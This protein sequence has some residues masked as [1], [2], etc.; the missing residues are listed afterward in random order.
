MKPTL[1]IDTTRFDAAL[2]VMFM[3]T[4][5][6][7]RELADEAYRGVIGMA[8]G[9]TPPMQGWKR[10]P[11]FTDPGAGESSWRSSYKPDYSGGKAAGEAGVRINMSALFVK[12]SKSR[13]KD[14]Q[15]TALLSAKLKAKTT[16]FLK[17]LEHKLPITASKWNELVK[18]GYSTVGNMAAGWNAAASR[19]NVRGIPNWIKRHGNKYGSIVVTET[20]TGFSFSARNNTKHRASNYFQSQ[21]Q[22][23]VDAQARKMERRSNFLTLQNAK[24]AG[25][26]VV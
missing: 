13:A 26:N 17:P 20:P 7:Q 12:A 21:L 1:S 5:R 11:S 19:F 4:K 23:A 22:M 18:L 2:R 8:I 25:F 9:L 15:A 3:E 14:E 10:K 16:P 6:T 24:K